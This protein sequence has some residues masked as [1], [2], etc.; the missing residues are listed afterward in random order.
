MRRIQIL[1]YLAN[2]AEDSI[3]AGYYVLLTK[4]DGIWTIQSW[5]NQWVY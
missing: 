4:E 5:I 1:V 3:G 2:E